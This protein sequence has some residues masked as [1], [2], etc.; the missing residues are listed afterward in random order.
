KVTVWAEGKDLPIGWDL[1][2]GIEVGH[3][4]VFLGA[5]PYLFFLSDPDNTGKC[6]K[7]EV[8]LQGF[9]SQDTHE[10]LNT[11][12]WGPDSNL[13]GLHGIFTNSEVKPN[14]PNASAT[15]VK[16]NAAIWRYDVKT[17]KFDI[18]AEGTSNPWGM[19]FDARGNCFVACCVIPHLFHIVPGGTYIRQ[20]G[21]SFNPYAYGLLDEICDHTHHKQ[22]G[23]AHAGLLVMEG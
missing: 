18:F 5:P 15:G 11:F 1:A 3:G 21:G 23:W 8:L 19:D 9:G 6:T 4:G 20:A 13:Y 7:Q 16:L 12:Q 10:T 2:S 22:S 17:K 14:E